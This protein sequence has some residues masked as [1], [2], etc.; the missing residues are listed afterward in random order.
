MAILYDTGLGDASITISSRFTVLEDVKYTV[1]VC[2][3]SLILET[4]YVKLI[5]ILNAY[6]HLCNILQ[7]EYSSLDGGISTHCLLKM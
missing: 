7:A 5:L 2:L 6:T 4:L 3:L 1:I